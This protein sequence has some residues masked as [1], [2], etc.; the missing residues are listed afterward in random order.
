MNADIITIGDEILIGQ[1]TDTNS[2]WIAEQLSLVGFHIRQITSVADSKKHIQS[3]LD[4]VSPFTD[5]VVMTGGLGPTEDDITKEVLADYFNS[6]L[7]E[8]KD[9]LNDI[10]SLI[11]FR[12][13]PLNEN[14]RKQAYVPENCTIIRNQ[15]GTAPVMWFEKDSTVYIS[16]PAV[17]YEMKKLMTESVI[18]I[19]IK[20]FNTPIF[21]HRTVLTYGLPESKLAERISDWEK[22]LNKNIKLAYLPS[23]ERIRL[24]LSMVCK[25]RSKAEEIIKTEIEKLKSYIDIAI[26]GFGDKF[27]Q[28][29][30]QELFI[31]KSQT[32]SVAESCTGGKIA[33]LLISVPGSSAY[34]KGGIV[35]YSDNIKQNLLKVPKKILQQHGAVSKKTVEYML[36]GQKAIYNT[37]YVAAVSGIAGPSGGT[38]DKPVG[39]VWIGV[40]NNEKTII[41]KYIFGNLRDVNIR[42]T[43]SRTLNMLRKLIMGIYE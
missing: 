13:F 33:S 6:K 5:L 31:S 22:N 34:F 11:S 15:F 10:K 24:R 41:K 19:I 12:G 2:Q 1:I 43:S 37:D 30:I 16:L 38:E 21:V 17:P 35:A 40:M 36:K 27:L 29:V 20:K 3:V 14:N 28:D 39:T 23:P 32:L 25:D 18:P 26:F 8:N 9:V 4:T 42:L 7:Y